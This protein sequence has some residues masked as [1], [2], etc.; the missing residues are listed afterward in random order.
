MDFQKL[1]LDAG[2][3]LGQDH[4]KALAF[5][6]SDL[7][8][9]N[10]TSVKSAS[11]LFSYLVDEDLLSAE[12]PH[13]LTELLL[14]IERTRLVRDLR[15][16]LDPSTS[17]NHISAYRKLLYKLSEDLTEEN[18]R[19]MKFL[20]NGKLPRKKLEENVTAL[21]VFQEM[22]HMDL[23]N[24]TNLNLLEILFQSC[25]PVS[26]EKINRFKEQQA[27]P[28]SGPVAQETGQPMSVSDPL[29]PYQGPGYLQPEGAG[30]LPDSQPK[31]RSSSTSSNTS[32]D[33]ANASTGGNKLTKFETGPPRINNNFNQQAPDTTDNEVSENYPMTA[34]K[35][36]FCLIINNHNFS[37]SI[38]PLSDREGTQIDQKCLI[39]V[40]E[41]LGFELEV[42]E[43]CK[44]EE[45]LSAVQEL[46]RR[47]H[48]DRDCLVCCILSHGEE[49][50][51][52]GVDGLTVGLKELKEPFTGLKCPS[53]LNKPKLFFIQACQGTRSQAPVYIEADGPDVG[54]IRSDARRDSIPNDADFLLA[55]AT[56][57]S[58]AS[59][60]Q[61]SLGTWFIQ[62]LCQNLVQMVPRGRNLMSILT[63]VNGDV[64]EKT[65]YTGLK[66]Q[67]PQPAFTLRKKVVFPI[68]QAPPPRLCDD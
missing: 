11:D 52:L 40:F 2:K 47:D 8:D 63:K 53:L 21:E 22:E 65:D 46:G 29:E 49:E 54:H 14:I 30:E 48:S 34:A 23:I 13:L 9:R 61:R 4:V 36:G 33:F 27:F 41:W 45:I 12:Q 58:H 26:I 68:P 15:L 16:P 10:L 20:L 56:V 1:L 28:H 24:E 57:P 38:K 50:S 60:R 43:D 32:I 25:C 6:C 7:L 19:D 18:L 64:S 5:L 44:R 17:G 51:V 42:Q 39:K 55:M 62:S 35:R 66:K 59:Y 3:A 31:A 37:K 67:M